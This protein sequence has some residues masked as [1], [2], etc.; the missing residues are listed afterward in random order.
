VSGYKDLYINPTTKEYKDGTTFEEIVALYKFD[1]SLR[2]LFLKH[3][4]DIEQKMRSLLSYYFT[5]HYG[6]NQKHYLTHTSYNT[7]SK[8]ISGVKKLIS[9]LKSIAV[10]S[11]HYPY[12]TY[13]RSHYG[14]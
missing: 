10:S 4:L 5:E 6:E 14:I 3:L 1:E 9:T 8:Y 7:H 2:E 12:I 11:I 13:Q